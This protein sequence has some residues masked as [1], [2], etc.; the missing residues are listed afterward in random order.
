[1]LD[2]RQ[3]KT[4]LNIAYISPILECRSGKSHRQS[5]CLFCLHPGYRSVKHR[6]HVINTTHALS[7]KIMSLLSL[8]VLTI[9]GGRWAWQGSISFAKLMGFTFEGIP[10]TASELDVLE[11]S[12]YSRSDRSVGRTWCNTSCKIQVRFVWKVDVWQHR[13]GQGNPF[14]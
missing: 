14:A 12:R 2:D 6:H 13:L 1:M 4:I 9:A 5:P 8:P 7:S 11:N 3:Y 10:F